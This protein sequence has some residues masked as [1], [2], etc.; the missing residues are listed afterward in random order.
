MFY[1]A[2]VGNRYETLVHVHEEQILGWLM[3]FESLS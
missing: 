3:D 2:P 1:H